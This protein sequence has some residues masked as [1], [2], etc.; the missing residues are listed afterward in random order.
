MTFFSYFCMRK[1]IK[2][3]GLLS[4]L[5]SAMLVLFTGCGDDDDGGVN[6][7]AQLEAK[8]VNCITT[9]DRL[10]TQ[11]PKGQSFQA[12]IVLAADEEWCSFD[13]TSQLATTAGGAVGEALP[14]YLQEN[15]TDKY[16]SAEIT[17]TY[18][19]GYSVT[20]RLWQM[21]DSATPEYDRAWGELPEYREDANYIYKTYNTTLIST[22]YNEGGYRRN[23]TVC[24]DRDLRVAHW[25]AYPLHGCYTQP[26]VGRTDDWAYDP[27]TQSPAIASSE[28]SSIVK[29]A[30]SNPSGVRG[31]QCPSADRYNTTATNAMTFY[32]TNIMP[33][34]WDF[35]GGSWG[36]LEIKIREWAPLVST[37][38]R[39]DTLF[40]VTGTHF[41]GTLSTDR[42]GKK[43]GYPDKC[44][45]VLL[46]QKSNQNKQIWECGADEL[47]AIGFIFPNS[48]AA[49]DMKLSAAACSV[50]DIE[51]Q[52][53]FKFFQNLDPAVADAVKSQKKT[54]DWS[55]IY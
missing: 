35:N 32:A 29:G 18:S 3:T 47:K 54:S 7:L 2:Q 6:S 10:L 40:V 39:Y 11:G 12:K 55:G 21:P 31:H 25:V 20:L 33:Q 19:G 14:L 51:D 4:I 15:R 22:K 17:V 48:A 30:F 52:T 45:K 27:N 34:N 8:T 13:P 37:R 5:L 1:F 9:T 28:Q 26:N 36:K 43:V 38:I 49:K 53:G 42:D 16:R 50:K 24:F 41:D 23:F 44:W 46:Q